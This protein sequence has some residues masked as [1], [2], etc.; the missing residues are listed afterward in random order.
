MTWSYIEKIL[1]NPWK[2]IK[3]KESTKTARYNINT[4]K[5]TV[6]LYT[7]KEQSENEIKKTIP[8]TNSSPTK[9]KQKTIKYL[10]INLT[11]VVQDLNTE[12]SV[13]R[14]ET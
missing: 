14:N 6:F 3:I 2:T 12:N 13:K 10:G 4:Q 1:R 11:K 8:I 9:S 5:S 7:S